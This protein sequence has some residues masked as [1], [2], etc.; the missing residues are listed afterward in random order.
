[1]GYWMMSLQFHKRTKA[2]THAGF[3]RKWASVADVRIEPYGFG[4]LEQ[5]VRSH[6]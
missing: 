4:Q 1:M 5:S 2:G 3:S 6:H